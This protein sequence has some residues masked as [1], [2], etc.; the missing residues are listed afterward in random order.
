MARVTRLAIPDGVTRIGVGAFQNLAYI[1]DI[2]LPNNDFSVANVGFQNLGITQL[3]VKKN[4]TILSAQAFDGI[5]KM[6]SAIFGGEVNAI[7]NQCFR[8][9][10]ACMLYDFSNCSAVPPLY[11]TASLGHTNGCV[12]K[13]PSA[14]FSTWQ[15]ETNWVDLTDVVWEA[16]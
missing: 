4:I 12:I 11:S 5:T 7:T 15:N 16:V 14:L 9:A 10:N 6:T 8:N 1:T 3:Y 2:E 13:V